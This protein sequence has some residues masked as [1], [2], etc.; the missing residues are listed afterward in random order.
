MSSTPLRAV[1]GVSRGFLLDGVLSVLKLLQKL[2]K[3]LSKIES[4][5]TSFKIREIAFLSGRLSNMEKSAR[6][7]KTSFC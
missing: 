4:F 7:F 3:F 6:N 5:G 2:Q 1:G